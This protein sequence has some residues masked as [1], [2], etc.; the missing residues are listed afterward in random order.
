MD[1]EKETYETPRTEIVSFEMEDVI[2][3]S[4]YDGSGN[5]NGDPSLS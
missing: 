5:D 4:V 2:T 1:N 3:T